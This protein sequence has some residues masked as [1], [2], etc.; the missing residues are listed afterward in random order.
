M[1]KDAVKA[2]ED[3]DQ[4]FE[5]C[6]LVVSINDEAR[7]EDFGVSD[8]IGGPVKGMAAIVNRATAFGRIVHGT[9]KLPL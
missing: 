4:I 8:N 3:I 7:G 1:G 9:E 2:T 6:I 5:S